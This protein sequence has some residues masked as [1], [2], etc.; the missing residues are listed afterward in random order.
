MREIKFRG[1]RLDNGEWAYG[2]LTRY[3]KEMSYIT[4][5]LLEQEVYQVKT[6][7]VGQY[8]GLR[9]KSDVEI[10]EGDVVTVKDC[11]CIRQFEGVVEFDNGSF[12]INQDDWEKNYRWQD[13][14]CEVIGNIH[15]RR[16]IT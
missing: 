5:D 9:D 8:T 14:E 12:L 4:V 7:T 10:Y 13:Y 15:E 1:K 3:S 6:S 16:E 11:F 2:C